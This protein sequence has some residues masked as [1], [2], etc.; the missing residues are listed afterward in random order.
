MVAYT[1]RPLYSDFAS[2]SYVKHIIKFILHTLFHAKY[3]SNPYVNMISLILLECKQ[4]N[5]YIKYFTFYLGQISF[6]HFV[7]L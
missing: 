6:S 2:R 3:D 4:L 5:S 7:F 1:R